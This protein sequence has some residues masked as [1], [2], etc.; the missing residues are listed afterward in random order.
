MYL[1]PIKLSLDTSA[2]LPK[3]HGRWPNA[4]VKF[5]VK[6]SRYCE[7]LPTRR[8]FLFLPFF[9]F[10]SL[11]FFRLTSSKIIKNKIFLVLSSTCVLLHYFRP[12]FTSSQTHHLPSSTSLL[13]TTARTLPFQQIFQHHFHDTINPN[14]M[15]LI[16]GIFWFGLIWVQLI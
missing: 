3:S 1:Y 10:C 16:P 11:P 15:I 9:T 7:N 12:F 14:P 4:V 8:L 5:F 2:F 13:F 6:V